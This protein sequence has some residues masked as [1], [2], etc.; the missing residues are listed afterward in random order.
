MINIV[1]KVD[2]YE[3][4]ENEEG[5][6]FVAGQRVFTTKPASSRYFGLKL[7]KTHIRLG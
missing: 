6:K 4:G 2:K 1:N 3:P 5:V 7:K